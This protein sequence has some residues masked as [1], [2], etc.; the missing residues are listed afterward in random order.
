MNS[1]YIAPH[2]IGMLRSHLNNLSS[3]SSV[4]SILFFMA[5]EEAYHEDELTPLLH[6][7]K[8]PIIGGVFPEVIVEGIRKNTGIL[9]IPLSFHL[10]TLLIDLSESTKKITKKLKKLEIEIV[11]FSNGL[12][13][14]FD[15]ISA[16]KNNLTKALF[17]FFGTISTY[18][19][20]GAG[21]L[22]F[23]SFPCI[24][25]NDGLHENAA[26]IG[27][28]NIPIALGVSHGW[29]SISEPLKITK[30]YTS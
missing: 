23:T 28:A 3:N 1:L 27:L 16:S 8:K 24:I 7:F 22:N 6:H 15:A 29:K 19:G 21:S 17:N 18:I 2:D 12:F 5:V 20:G 10:N 30:A 25:N 9:I 26:I 13:V 4:I 14:F 11:D